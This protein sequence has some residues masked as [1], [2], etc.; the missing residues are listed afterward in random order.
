[1]INLQKV[2]NPA[3]CAQLFPY[4]GNPRI[5]AGEPLK[6]DVLK[7][8][9]KP[10]NSADYNVTFNTAQ[11]MRLQAIFPDGVCD[12]TKPGIGQQPLAGTWLSYPSPGSFFQLR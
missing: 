4:F 1:L 12:Y 2:T 10:V 9:L 7:C 3:Q 11:F 6:Q 8:Q 5:A